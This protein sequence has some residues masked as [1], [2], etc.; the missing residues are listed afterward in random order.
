M[1][2]SALINSCSFLI[3]F[4]FA[5]R[6]GFSFCVFGFLE[7]AARY[8]RIASIY[9]HL[10][11]AETALARRVGSSWNSCFQ[12]VQNGYV[13]VDFT[14]KITVNYLC[15]L[16]YLPKVG[17]SWNSCFRLGH[18]TPAQ[19]A[20]FQLEQDELLRLDIDVSSWF[21]NWVGKMHVLSPEFGVH[22][23]RSARVFFLVTGRWLGWVFWS[24][25]KHTFCPPVFGVHNARSA[26]EGILFRQ[27]ALVVPRI[28]GS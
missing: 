18:F 3:D 20:R 2:K 15:L 28:R 22:N 27:D 24:R 14:Y 4:T 11:H 9:A 6:F 23:A 7:K 16:T 10:L 19:C 21:K 12:L 8:S 25:V 5:N 1:R 17:S 26:R 13:R